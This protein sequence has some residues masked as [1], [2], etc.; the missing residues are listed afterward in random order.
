MLMGGARAT[1]VSIRINSRR[2]REAQAYQ[3]LCKAGLLIRAPAL[4]SFSS[5]THTSAGLGFLFESDFG[6]LV[7]RGETEDSELEHMPLASVPQP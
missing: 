7:R 4:A 6:E 1:V 5:R 3:Q 2:A